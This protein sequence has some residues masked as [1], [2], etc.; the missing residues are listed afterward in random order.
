ASLR[1]SGTSLPHRRRLTPDVA[2]L[3]LADNHAEWPTTWLGECRGHPGAVRDAV[4]SRAAALPIQAIRGAH[5]RVD[6][7][8]GHA[9][10]DSPGSIR[11]GPY[12]HH[13]CQRPTVAAA[14]A[15]VPRTAS[16]PPRTARTDK[17]PDRTAKAR[18]QPRANQEHR[19]GLSAY[20]N[21][22]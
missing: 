21:S 8:R 14:A 9:F 18:S 11:P 16:R 7:V 1:P 10:P 13:A 3:Q 20:R 12:Q 2:S 22:R 5:D 15:A 17:G 4:S 6:G 19:T